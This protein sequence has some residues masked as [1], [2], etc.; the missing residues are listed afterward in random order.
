MTRT[1]GA[2]TALAALAAL[3]SVVALTAQA[4]TAAQRSVAPATV[5]HAVDGSEIHGAVGFAP[6]AGGGTSVSLTIHGL[7]ASAKVDARLHT[8]WSLQSL[9]R[10]S[11]PLP[12][13]RASATGTYRAA[14]LLRSRGHDVRSS[15]VTDGAH[16]VVIRTGGRLVAYAH[17]PRG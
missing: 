12:G 2:L 14:G 11:T 8:G 15:A 3:A 6:T 5:L 1:T 10:S 9:S 17:V 4:G 16:T 7:P 13:G